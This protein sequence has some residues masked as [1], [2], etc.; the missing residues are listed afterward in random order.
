MPART[1]PLA[2]IILAV[3]AMIGPAADAT[4]TPSESARE[5]ADAVLACL[6]SGDVDLEHVALDRIRHGLHGEWFTS[7]VVDALPGLP[8]A[9]QA[10]VLVAL[11]DRGDPA[12]VPAAAALVASSE[13]SVR[14]AA[15]T[16]LGR[17]GRSE[18]LPTLL[19]LATADGETGREARRALVVIETPDA[20]AS[21]RT[22][23]ATATPE[24][25]A[26]IIDVL[27]ERRD[28]ASMPLFVAAAD[29]TPVERAAAFRAL[30]RYGGADQLDAMV[31]GLLN[32]SGDDRKAAE[33]AI[34]AVCTTS[35]DA[36]AAADRLVAGF[37]AADPTIQPSLLPTLARVGGPKVMAIID[38]ML[39]DPARR[40]T[41]LVALSKWPDATVKDKLFDLYGSATDP[42]E[43]ELVLGTLIRIAPLPDNKLD[44]RQK[45]ELVRKTMGLCERRDDKARLIER[46]NAIRTID[47]FRFVEP[48]LDDPDLAEA[49]CRS[50]V[51]L[52]HHQKLRD[53]N[54]AEVMAAL[55]RVIAT[56]K[57]PELTERAAR[58]KAGRTWDRSQKN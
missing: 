32:S 54:K 27:A 30:A 11:A 14:S 21:L 9:D 23:A 4:P 31:R 49:A 39:N 6:T 47:T 44:D 57:N 7:R 56:T 33:A 12:A 8:A 38:S 16:L 53:A 43:K 51:E 29:A 22:A 10:L 40:E 1:V 52:A 19:S 46:A 13:P 18:D 37:A 42:S 45:L 20:V 36:H 3:V 26:A 35:P 24:A 48:F 17:L 15:I 41:G 34:V 28:A 2:S 58:Y 55:D 50:V 5:A 25:R